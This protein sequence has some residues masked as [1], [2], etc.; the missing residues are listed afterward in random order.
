MSEMEDFNEDR[1]LSY[2]LKKCK[3]ANL[4]ILKKDP[5][6]VKTTNTAFLKTPPLM[7]LFVPNKRVDDWLNMC[8]D[9]VCV[10][11]CRCA[12]VTVTHP[13]AAPARPSP[14]LFQ[15][16]DGWPDSHH[17]HN[18]RENLAGQSGLLMIHMFI[19]Y[20]PSST[21]FSPQPL[22]PPFL[23]TPFNKKDVCLVLGQRAL[24]CALSTCD[25]QRLMKGRKC[26][27]Q[28]R[29]LSNPMY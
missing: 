16:W 21:P 24:L 18:E 3:Q 11:V 10:R 25:I 15:R 23:S 19:S 4:W 12:C 9:P 1:S 14:P 2:W 7:F 28:E 13:V 17:K 29:L 8:I 6:F 20:L 22:S 26:P 5:F 27:R